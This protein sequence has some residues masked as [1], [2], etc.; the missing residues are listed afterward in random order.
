MLAAS[1]ILRF[2]QKNPCTQNLYQGNRGSRFGCHIFCGWFIGEFLWQVIILRQFVWFLATWAWFEF[3]MKKVDSQNL[4]FCPFLGSEQSPELPAL[5]FNVFSAAT[6]QS[7]WA[8]DVNVG[9]YNQLIFKSSC[10]CWLINW[11]GESVRSWCS[12]NGIGSRC[13]MLLR[14]G[15]ATGF[16]QKTSHEDD[17]AVCVW[18]PVACDTIWLS[19]SWTLSCAHLPSWSPWQF[20]CKQMLCKFHHL[21]SHAHVSKFGAFR[22]VFNKCPL[23]FLL[24]CVVS[25]IPY[26]NNV[27]T[28]SHDH[29]CFRSFEANQLVT[30]RKQWCVACKPT[31]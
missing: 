15:H 11:F 3:W 23:F 12:R 14:H 18:H 17:V 25:S 27:H 9:W 7:T 26:P 6:N 24:E 4:N 29:I 19:V 28:S 22:C 8:V 1:W 10:R 31:T 16:Q 5:N 21:P 20:Q 13:K 30:S 2:I